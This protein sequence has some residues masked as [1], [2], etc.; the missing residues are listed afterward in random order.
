MIINN[1]EIL[2]KLD[3]IIYDSNLSEL[4]S[5]S[6]GLI[7]I[8][9]LNMI[10][11]GE[12]FGFSDIDNIFIISNKKIHLRFANNNFY[13][14]N[15]TTLL[16]DFEVWIYRGSNLYYIIPKKIIKSI[17]DDPEAYRDHTNINLR[18]V[19]ID[20]LKDTCGYATNG[21]KI[22]ISFYRNKTINDF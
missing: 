6:K 13:N 1:P 19:S 2:E 5:S 22:D 20:D 17:Y 9:V 10:S 15:Q 21:Q 12:G 16:A 7:K 4:Q 3:R 14:L 8:E 18:V 11:D